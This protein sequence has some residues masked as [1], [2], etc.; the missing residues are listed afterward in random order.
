MDTFLA[1]FI[2]VGGISAL[3]YK[4]FEAVPSHGDSLVLNVTTVNTTYNFTD[5]IMSNIT[6][7]CGQPRND[8][9]HIFRDPVNSDLPWPGL[10]IRTTFIST[11]FWCCD[12]VLVEITRVILSTFNFKSLKMVA[13]TCI[14]FFLT[15]NSPKNVSSQKYCSCQRC[16]HICIIHQILAHVHHHFAR[17]D[18]QDIIS[19]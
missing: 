13:R 12:Q 9:F 19:R 6:Q 14:V 1:G 18:Q 7:Q 8:A 16:D 3:I 5:A 17:H 10:M 4:Y 2:K 15:V 11:W